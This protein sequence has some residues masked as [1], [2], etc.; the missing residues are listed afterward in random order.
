M[1]TEELF[2]DADLET[3]EA[4]LNQDDA[5]EVLLTGRR[6]PKLLER[7]KTLVFALAR[8]EQVT[9]EVESLLDAGDWSRRQ[10]DGW[11]KTARL[12]L[13]S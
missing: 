1:I 8:G 13:R 10:L 6:S 5:D 9:G 2:T 3:A 7:R 12:R 11:V 4:E